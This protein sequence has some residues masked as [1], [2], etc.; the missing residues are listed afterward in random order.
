MRAAQTGV[1]ASPLMIPTNTEDRRR[2]SLETRFGA[3]VDKLLIAQGVVTADDS[4]LKLIEVIARD[5]PQSEEKLGTVR[6]S[7]SIASRI[8]IRLLTFD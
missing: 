8:T 5:A 4:R 6:K 2:M 1:H 3:T 7:C